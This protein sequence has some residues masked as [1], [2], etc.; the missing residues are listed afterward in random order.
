MTN[1]TAWEVV[2]PFLKLGMGKET[3]SL[4]TMSPPFAHMLFSSYK[5][6]LSLAGLKSQNGSLSLT[7]QLYC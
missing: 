2:L 1:V 4:F 5:K 3:N 6:Y 7:G